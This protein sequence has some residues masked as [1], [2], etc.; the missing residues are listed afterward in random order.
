MRVCTYHDATSHFFTPVGIQLT[1]TLH[2]HQR[3]LNLWSDGILMSRGCLLDS[4][5]GLK[6]GTLGVIVLYDWDSVSPLPWD[7]FRS[8]SYHLLT[9]LIWPPSTLFNTVHIW[10]RM[11]SHNYKLF[12]CVYVLDLTMAPCVIP[13]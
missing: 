12:V 2:L 10:V 3:A 5:L 9:F 8:C 13:E 1:R 6:W 4:D 11:K 7:T